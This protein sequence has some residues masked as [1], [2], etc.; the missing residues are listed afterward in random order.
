[1]LASGPW[2]E[3]VMLSTKPEVLSM[4][5]GRQNRTEPWSQVRSIKNLVK[6][7][8][9][10]FELCEW[11]D[12]L[13]II[14][15]T[16]SGNEIIWARRCE[17]YALQQMQ[18]RQLF[19]TT[20]YTRFLFIDGTADLITFNDLMIFNRPCSFMHERPADECAGYCAVVIHSHCMLYRSTV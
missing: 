20:E 15:R 5:Q 18:C 1:M 3:N 10:V 9:V 12:I 11:T 2:Y 7:G 8:R 14:L 6:I 4:S 17:D 16:T 13:I 19:L